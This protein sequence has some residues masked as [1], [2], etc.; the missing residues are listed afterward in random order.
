MFCLLVC[1]A[2]AG[3]RQPSV[4]APAGAPRGS[5]PSAAM[6][7]AEVPA[8]PSYTPLTAGQKFET[9]AHRIYSPY[10]FA[11]AGMN[12]TWAQIVGDWPGY[13]GGVAGW[14]KRVGASYADGQASGFFRVFLLPTLLHQDPRYFPS[15]KRGIVPRF[16]YAGTRVLITRQDSGSDG[17]NYSQVLGTL[18]TTSVGNAYYPERDRGFGITMSRTFGSLVSE[19]G[20]N[21]L[22]EFWPDI[23][24]VFKRHAPEKVKK[25]QQKIPAKV[26]REL[27]P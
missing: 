27:A 13:G 18:F 12:G 11:S 2:A 1:L 24:G 6:E 26:R 8:A 3:Q 10:T 9:F 14:G 5:S 23:K 15:K 4:K 19:A 21:V 20:S 25:I 7:K 16:W 17:F 22:R